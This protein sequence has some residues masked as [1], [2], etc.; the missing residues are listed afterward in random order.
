LHFCII[1][2]IVPFLYPAIQE[3]F[4]QV[5]HHAF[6][7][8]DPNFL[9]YTLSDPLL[10][11]SAELV[12]SV[13]ETFPL[14]ECSEAFCLIS[15]SSSELQVHSSLI[16][17]NPALRL[18]HPLPAFNHH[19]HFFTCFEFPSR[20]GALFLVASRLSCWQRNM[21]ALPTADPCLIPSSM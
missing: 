12:A 7:R 18:M 14:E 5:A 20:Q 3:W 17:C 9:A 16:A 10:R 15:S 21:V 11:V 2:V 4:H 8:F 19:F 13:S 6:S 1:F